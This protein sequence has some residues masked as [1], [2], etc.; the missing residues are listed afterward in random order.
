MKKKE[1]PDVLMLEAYLEIFDEKFKCQ[2]ES[3]ELD[4]IE[5]IW[6]TLSSKMN[7]VPKFNFITNNKLS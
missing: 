4:N 6:E 5:E 7:S 1:H 2:A 3:L